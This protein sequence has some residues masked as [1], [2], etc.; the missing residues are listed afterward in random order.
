MKKPNRVMPRCTERSRW[1]RAIGAA[2]LAAILSVVVGHG[3]LEQVWTG[4]GVTH[5][6]GKNLGTMQ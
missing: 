3:L 1:N 4:T 6:W 5:V 2:I